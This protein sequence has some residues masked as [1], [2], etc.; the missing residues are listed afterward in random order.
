MNITA[1]SSIKTLTLLRGKKKRRKE[2]KEKR[3]K[4]PYSGL[5]KRSA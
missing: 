1:R 4:S 2:K 3:G 5:G